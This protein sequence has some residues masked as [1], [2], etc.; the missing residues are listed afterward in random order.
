MM[1]SNVNE[2]DFVRP[3]GP[4]P[5]HRRPTDGRD[6]LLIRQW[7]WESPSGL[8]IYSQNVLERME[9]DLFLEKLPCPTTELATQNLITIG[10]HNE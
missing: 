5:K 3:I 1:E 6:S 10:I 7:P 9:S 2:F 8:N 4:F